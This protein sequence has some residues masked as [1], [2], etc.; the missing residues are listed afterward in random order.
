M[1]KIF[2]LLTVLVSSF[3]LNNTQAQITLGANINVGKQPVWGPVGYDYVENYY[4]PD[5]DA[6]YNVPSRRYTYL[7]GS[8]WVTTAS[9]PARYRSYDLYKGY[10]VVVNEKNPYNNADMYRTKYASFKGKHDQ[11]IIRNSDD[12]K[13]FVIKN[14]P[15]HL[16]WMNG[17]GN[18]HNNGN[19]KGTGVG[20]GKGNGN[21]DGKGN[22]NFNNKN[23]KSKGKG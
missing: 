6:Y 5:I 12:E 17:K 23:K 13:Y 21:G 22:G 15:K 4:M 18:G 7:D 11:V 10:K 20:I 14:H 3:S 2:V 16:K 8:R 19:G 1:K 9:L